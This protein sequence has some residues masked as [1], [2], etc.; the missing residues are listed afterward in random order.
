M[1][2]VHFWGSRV[3]RAGAGGDWEQFAHPPSCETLVW[4]LQPHGTEQ[5]QPLCSGVRAHHGSWLNASS[6]GQTSEQAG[7]EGRRPVGLTLGLSEGA[8][9]GT[10]MLAVHFGTSLT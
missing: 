2:S 7:T 4:S 5:E 10:E 1:G 6:K 8:Q 3:S 9:E